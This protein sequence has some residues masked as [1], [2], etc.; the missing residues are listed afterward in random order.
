MATVWT[1]SPIVAGT[2]EIRAV[3]INELRT[4]INNE[5]SRRAGGIKSWTD[6]TLVVP[7]GANPNIVRESHVRELRA[8]ANYAE[9][10]DCVTDLAPVQTWTDDPIVPDVTPIRATHINELRTYFNQLETQCTCNCDSH[11]ACNS[12]CCNCD[13]CGSNCSPH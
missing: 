4:A 3:H 13:H 12:Q 9:T 1:D 6:P 5:I 8:A 10:I 2:T 7:P 11:C